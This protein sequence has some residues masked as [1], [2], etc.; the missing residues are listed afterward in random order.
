MPV[1]VRKVPAEGQ[2]DIFETVTLDAPKQPPMP[3]YEK[4]VPEMPKKAMAEPKE[5]YN[6]FG[7]LTIQAPQEKSEMPVYVRK[8][9]MSPEKYIPYETVTV[10][11]P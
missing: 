8:V 4:K 1:Y 11:A 5:E 2:F 10:E 3:V 7:V 6:P 9:S